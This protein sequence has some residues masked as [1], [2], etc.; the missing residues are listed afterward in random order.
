MKPAWL[1]LL[2]G[3][4]AIGAGAT[5]VVAE[6]TGTVSA[7]VDYPSACAGQDTMPLPFVEVSIPSLALVGHTDAS[8]HFSL[9]AGNNAMYTVGSSLRSREGTGAGQVV[10]SVHKYLEPPPSAEVQCET[11]VPCVIL[12]DD[13]NSEQNER[14][15]YY[16]A[17]CG[18]SEIHARYACPSFVGAEIDFEVDGNPCQ[19]SFDGD[20]VVLGR[21]EF[22]CGDLGRIGSVV[23]HELGHALD[24][25][26]TGD[27]TPCDLESLNP[28]E[29]RC[30]GFA[31]LV[32]RAS[33]V[34]DAYTANGYYISKC[35]Y[36]LRQHDVLR[37]W[38]EDRL[39]GQDGEILS[40]FYWDASSVLDPPVA[41]TYLL[42]SICQCDLDDG[43]Q[44]SANAYA[45]KA[46]VGG[47]ASEVQG[48]AASHGFSWA[49][50]CL[51]LERPISVE[52]G[53]ANAEV[54]G[55]DSSGLELNIKSALA[56]VTSPVGVTID[57]NGYV[58]KAKI[59]LYSVDGRLVLQ[60]YSGELRKGSNL[61]QWSG[62]DGLGRKAASGVYVVRVESK[63]GVLSKKV[64][65][66]GRD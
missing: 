29:A 28:I 2:L 4:V 26:A 52:S 58:P 32:I 41:L 47:H 20:V 64:I 35:G 50:Q 22:P 43:Y 13:E 21:E 3:P 57:A 9:S 63:V 17:R 25:A 62:V 37:R 36:G 14:T 45:Q 66:L 46:F 59:E 60:L 39:D 31:A 10:F 6:I 61:F 1:L 15:T 12:F 49:P 55:T 38:P 40:G 44:R 42:Q 34:S 5:H 33:G 24:N 19:A 11:G 56:T 30:D 48:V 7:V 23:L 27:Q 8:G 65:L 54:V 51:T 16:W 18:F 53:L